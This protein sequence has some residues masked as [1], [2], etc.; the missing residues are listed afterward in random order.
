[1]E[2]ERRQRGQRRNEDRELDELRDM[3]HTAA[4]QSAQ[5]LDLAKEAMSLQNKHLIE[6]ATN[7]TEM[8]GELK[9]LKETTEGQGVGLNAR[10]DQQDGRM[11]AILLSVAGAAVLLF[12]QVVLTATKLSP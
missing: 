11:W 9:A 6:C 1:M 10:L 12:V 4:R 3:V 8:R 7:H 5:A 2:T